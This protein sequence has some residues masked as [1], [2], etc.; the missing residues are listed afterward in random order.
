MK[1]QRRTRPAAGQKAW[2][3]ILAGDALLAQGREA[4]AIA[5]YR[6]AVEAD[7]ASS[8]AHRR[9]AVALYK[10]GDLE[11]ARGSAQASADL[12]PE[13]VD[14]WFTLGLILRDA[15][16]LPGALE[17]FD[18]VLALQPNHVDALHHRGRALYESGQPE[19]AAA[20]F[21][22]AAELSP[23]SADLAH[24]LAI[25]YV[26]GGHWRAAEEAFARC[27]ELEP[28]NPEN[29]YELGHAHEYD[30]TTPDEAAEAA[31]RRA[32]ELDPEHLPAQFRLA[33]LRTRR[34]VADPE[35]GEE[36]GRALLQ[37]AVREDLPALFPD[38]HLV[39]YLLGAIL[40]DDDQR[41]EEAT[42]AYERCLSLRPRFA[43]AHN[44]LG[45]LARRRGALDEAAGHFTHAVLADPTYDPALQNL[46]RVLYDQPDDLAVEQ[47]R[48]IV[49]LVPHAAPDVITRLVGHIIDAAKSEAYASSYDKVHEIKNLIGV[50][51]ARMRKVLLS[52]DCA[53]VPEGPELMEMQ[54]RAFDAIRGYLSAF[55]TT[56]GEWELLDCGE[57]LLK[58]VRQMAVTKPAGVQVE[59]AVEPGLPPLM[60][61][62]RR[63]MQLFRNLTVNAFEAL[64][65]GG[66]LRVAAEAIRLEQTA[67]SSSIRR[68]VR[69]VFEDTGPG[70]SA[71][72]MRRAFDP[73][74][75]T[76]ATGSG[77]GLVVVS[78]VV[79]E[80]AG[81]V[82]LARAEMGGTRVVVEL[83]ERPQPESATGRLRLRPVI[84]VDW[85]RLIQAEVDAI[86]PSDGSTTHG[87]EGSLT[88]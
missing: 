33:V 6:R 84:F 78:Q 32:V 55:E 28:D 17:A 80:H 26:A 47:L 44:N 30:V 48:E 88:G 18:R 42:Q 65:N 27:I 31:Y 87:G 34:R 1:R 85:Q 79:R 16:D 58:A 4:E 54:G 37:L 43:P 25:A 52:E 40:D 59:Y 13:A 86:S 46:C 2:E 75:T 5:E 76:K 51:G 66:M 10:H 35:A 8:E 12:S 24:D 19:A 21:A 73:G 7:G 20:S 71:E 61:D 45:V 49:D 9:L 74:Y 81:T 82:G 64:P 63:L 72:E 3:C 14:P 41:A 38:A 69:V 70:M 39:H 53:H 77:Y 11:L 83:P 22:R 67:P 15:R 29:Y 36:A 68:G 57:A 56:A 23:E 50:L 62:R 60:G